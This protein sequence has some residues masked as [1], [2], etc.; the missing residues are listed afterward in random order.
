MLIF[1]IITLQESVDGLEGLMS[2]LQ[3]CNFYSLVLTSLSHLTVG[4]GPAETSSSAGQEWDLSLSHLSS[5]GPGER[6]EDEEE[7]GQSHTS[8]QLYGATLKLLINLMLLD[9]SQVVPQLFSHGL[10]TVVVK[11][12]RSLVSHIEFSQSHLQAT[13]ASLVL[14]RVVQRHQPALSATIAC[15]TGLEHLA[16]GVLAADLLPLVSLEVLAALLEEGGWGAVRVV[17][18]VTVCPS[19]ILCPIVTAL[20]V[21]APGHLQAAAASFLIGL[22]QVVLHG[23]EASQQNLHPTLTGALDT[24]ATMPGNKALCPG[25]ELCRHLVQLVCDAPQTPDSAVLGH[26]FLECLKLLLLISHSAREAAFHLRPC[27]LPLLAWPLQALQEKVTSVNLHISG[28]LLRCKDTKEEVLASIQSLEVATNWVLGGSGIEDVCETLLARLHPLWVPALHTPSIMKALL[29]FLLSSTA[30][31]QCCILLTRTSAMPGV[32]V[33]ATRT[34]WP[35]L[36]CVATMVCQYLGRLAEETGG[37]SHCFKTLSK[38]SLDRALSV[39]TNC[40]RVPECT[41]ILNKVDMVGSVMRWLECRAA[42]QEGVAVTCRVVQLLSLLTTHQESCKVLLK[43]QHWTATIKELA[44]HKLIRLHALR[45]AATM[46]LGCHSSASLLAQGGLVETLLEVLAQE[47]EEQNETK[48][49]EIALVTIWALA[50]N[51]QRGKSIL[52]QSPLRHLLRHLAETATDR[53]ATLAKTILPM[54]E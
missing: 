6:E 31:H 16:L 26:L 12:L 13:E 39:V 19:P 24:P 53:R 10:V 42:L 35:L 27:L 30:L 2:L 38:E 47:K 32:P 29:D 45:V 46:A 51:N 48:C 44:A 34:R 36:A 8:I 3:H 1:N 14:L 49:C 22:T 15:N 25:W 40:A 4:P 50:A 5:F 52:R 7:G 11:Q 23:R 43:S 28:N 33:S 9:P 21:S 37:L 54:L 17:E 20:H 18:W 41:F